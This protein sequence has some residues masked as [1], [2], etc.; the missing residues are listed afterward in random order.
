MSSTSEYNNIIPVAERR[1]PPTLRMEKNTQFFIFKKKNAKKSM[2]RVTGKEISHGE[3]LSSRNHETNPLKISITQTHGSQC[4][5]WFSFLERIIEDE[6]RNK[7][8]NESVCK[9]W[10]RLILI[11][12]TIFILH[13]IL[14]SVYSSSHT[15][16]L[17]H[18]LDYR[19]LSDFIIWSECRWRRRFIH[20]QCAHVCN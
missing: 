15:H 1:P 5:R 16:N 20:R 4:E 13:F 3:S 19:Y 14:L 9:M 2:S 10:D 17:H 8:S 6:E 11:F 7:L 12:Y 18:P